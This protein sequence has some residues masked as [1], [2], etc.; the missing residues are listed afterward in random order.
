M[1]GNP[2]LRTPPPHSQCLCRSWRRSRSRVSS[3]Q[4]TGVV[5]DW[6]STRKEGQE[7]EKEEERG[8]R[9]ESNG[10]KR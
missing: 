8:E 10:G 2:R 1:R 7:G 3:G 5:G 6:E 4:L 9:K